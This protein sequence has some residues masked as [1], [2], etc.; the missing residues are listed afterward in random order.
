MNNNGKLKHIWVVVNKGNGDETI[1]NPC[2][3]RS[4]AREIARDYNRGRRVSQRKMVVR[5]FVS[6]S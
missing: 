4:R 6:T 3:S 5:K 1:V 2:R